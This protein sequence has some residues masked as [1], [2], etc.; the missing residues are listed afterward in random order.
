MA[1]YLLLVPVCAISEGGGGVYD[2]F[3][4]DVAAPCRYQDVVIQTSHWKSCITCDLT[5][6]T[7]L[8]LFVI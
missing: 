8:M 4:V 3:S 6:T 1:A 2:W 5:F 7:V